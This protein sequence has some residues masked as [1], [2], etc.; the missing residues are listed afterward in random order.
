M[1]RYEENFFN[2]NIY[3]FRSYF[4][5]GHYFFRALVEKCLPRP[6]ARRPF[7]KADAIVVLAGGT[8]SRIEAAARLYREGFGEKLLFS[9]FR[10]YPETYTSSLMKTYALKLGVPEGNIITC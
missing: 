8:G 5:Y 4:D 3:G 6:G 10:V 7:V 2:E 1:R 9:G